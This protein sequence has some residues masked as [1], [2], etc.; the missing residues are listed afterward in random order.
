[1]NPANLDTTNLLL[2]IMAAVSVL[3]AVLLVG[4]GVMAYR[5]YTRAM[6]MVREVE[7]RQIAP[8]VARADGLMVRV[9]SILVDLKDITARV[10][11]RTERVD[12]A[13]RNTIDRVDETA[14]R[15]R[16]SVSSRIYRVLTLVH[17]ARAAVDGF[18]HHS[19][20][21]DHIRT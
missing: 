20:R 8:L 15:M 21:A 6:D 3:E 19:R 7:S 18:L 11:N 10:T 9:D 5:F 2:G 4:I 16:S 1:M 14:G 12:M 17:T 13:I